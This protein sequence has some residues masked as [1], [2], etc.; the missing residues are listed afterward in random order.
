M[1]ELFGSVSSLASNADVGTRILSGVLSQ[2]GEDL[3]RGV[4]RR[5]MKS[6]CDWAPEA[7]TQMRTAKIEE[8]SASAPSGVPR[9]MQLLAS[10]RSSSFR[11]QN[12]TPKQTRKRSVSD[13]GTPTLPTTEIGPNSSKDS[14]PAVSEGDDDDDNASED[15]NMASRLLNVDSDSLSLRPTAPDVIVTDRDVL[16]ESATWHSKRSGSHVLPLQELVEDTNM[17]SFVRRH[18]FLSTEETVKSLSG[19]TQVA[20]GSKLGSDTRKNN[21]PSPSDG[22]SASLPP[23]APRFVLLNSSVNPL[24]A[25]TA[26]AESTPTVRNLRTRPRSASTVLRE[27]SSS[28]LSISAE[29]LRSYPQSIFSPRDPSAR[30]QLPRPQ[31]ALGLIGL[32]EAGAGM[33]AENEESDTPRRRRRTSRLSELSTAGRRTPRQS[34]I[35]EPLPSL[36][37]SLPTKLHGVRGRSLSSVQTTPQ[38]AAPAARTRSMSP[39]GGVDDFGLISPP[40]PSLSVSAVPSSPHG[41]QHM[42]LLGVVQ[43]ASPER[44]GSARGLGAARPFDAVPE[45]TSMRGDESERPS[46]DNSTLI[47]PAMRMRKRSPRMS[48]RA[49]PSM[50]HR[51]PNPFISK[52]QCDLPASA[53]KA[54]AE[55]YST[56]EGFEER[57]GGVR[58]PAHRR[59]RSPAGLV[60]GFE[61]VRNL[62]TAGMTQSLGLE[63][64]KMES[65]V[66]PSEPSIAAFEDEVDNVSTTDLVIRRYFV[67]D[68]EVDKD[69]AKKSRNQDRP[70]I[71]HVDVL[72]EKWDA[73]SITYVDP[74][75]D[76][77]RKA[78]IERRRFKRIT[79]RPPTRKFGRGASES[80]QQRAQLN[81]TKAVI[82]DVQWM[83]RHPE[84]P[85]H[86]KI[87]YM[88]FPSGSGTR[89]RDFDD[90]GDGTGVQMGGEAENMNLQS[91]VN[92]LAPAANVDKQ[93]NDWYDQ[94]RNL[95]RYYD[96]LVKQLATDGETVVYQAPH[97]CSCG[98]ACC[99]GPS[100]V[101]ANHG[102]QCNKTTKLP[103]DVKSLQDWIVNLD[104]RTDADCKL[105][106]PLCQALLAA[107]VNGKLDFF[108]QENEDLKKELR[109]AQLHF[110]VT[111]RK[112]YIEWGSR[113]PSC[114]AWKSRE[115]HW[116][117][118]AAKAVGQ[119]VLDHTRSKAM[120]RRIRDELHEAKGEIQRLEEQLAAAH[121]REESLKNRVSEL[122]QGL[123]EAK[124]TI[125][126]QRSEMKNVENN[127]KEVH[128]KEL[129]QTYAFLTLRASVI[130]VRERT[131]ARKMAAMAES[132][133]QERDNL[134]SQI[135]HWRSK[136][137]KTETE[138]Q[139]VKE[140]GIIRDYEIL[141]SRNKLTL[142]QKCWEEL[143]EVLEP[144]LNNCP[145]CYGNLL[146]QQMKERV[147]AAAKALGEELHLESMHHM[148]MSGILRCSFLENYLG[149]KAFKNCFIKLEN[150]SAVMKKVNL[151]TR[152]RRGLLAKR[153]SR[154]RASASAGNG[155]NT[156]RRVGANVGLRARKLPGVNV[157]EEIPE[158][159]EEQEVQIKKDIERYD[160][161]VKE[162]VN[163]GMDKDVLLMKAAPNLGSEEDANNV[164][165]GLRSALPSQEAI[166][167]YGENVIQGR[168]G[169]FT[170]TERFK[171]QRIRSLLVD[172]FRG[173]FK[174]DELCVATG[175][176]P[177][178]FSEYFTETIVCET[179]DK[180]K[181]QVKIREVLS[182]L[183]EFGR[184]DR[185][186]YMACRFLGIYEALPTA[187]LSAY[188][189]VIHYVAS[190]FA[191]SHGV[192]NVAVAALAKFWKMISDTEELFWLSRDDVEAI[193]S[194][195]IVKYHV[196]EHLVHHPLTMLLQHEGDRSQ[197]SLYIPDYQHPQQYRIDLHEL[198]FLMTQALEQYESQHYLQAFNTHSQALLHPGKFSY[199]EFCS[200]TAEFNEDLAEQDSR[201]LYV[202]MLRDFADEEGIVRPTHFMLVARSHRALSLHREDEEKAQDKGE[203]SK[204]TSAQQARNRNE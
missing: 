29:E 26:A 59:P 89:S 135:D 181:S 14:L 147:D 112:S 50:A 173:K 111:L 35:L 179:G 104:P 97:L 128:E 38:G 204:Q 44:R 125:F 156:R 48:A 103:I 115:Q 85:K 109:E 77:Q 122:E 157:P 63:V 124:R 27:R 148:A 81:I 30:G 139:A 117:K 83:G 31:T 68:L 24:R 202:R 43:D 116:H 94:H 95:T 153:S 150:D 98:C 57:K 78:A 134:K 178:Q 120:G 159:T 131:R 66:P 87:H 126:E 67:P 91:E 107:V 185:I 40:S 167:E 96:E 203:T 13:I 123:A 160:E 52:T 132:A 106:F 172:M 113:C 3:E 143:Y 182:I 161:E 80:P 7:I 88:E 22:L 121:E 155:P 36:S 90:G 75:R 56:G 177:M 190:R 45:E 142:I 152:A 130:Y 20:P 53:V 82:G 144:T 168:W 86:R 69:P 19:G 137:V 149:E 146:D 15:S 5:L 73:G 8:L 49:S 39:G 162:A 23:S 46:A 197:T 129:C 175:S 188:L 127:I 176:N 92:V 195:F 12:S 171:V 180:M 79:G 99:S 47:S 165:K 2:F 58:S 169:R 151:L 10:K 154:L 16:V 76:A 65:L 164:P 110:L 138:L 105:L 62:P 199:S 11:D 32:Y 140:N 194:R 72:L 37:Q 60:S 141:A 25:A 34:L 158:L 191:A 42:P 21:R 74:E 201:H 193:V 198:L 192:G 33:G 51:D 184:R 54:G 17:T 71:G 100:T 166:Q 119:A 84:A 6:K 4:E 70:Y 9:Q 101:A 93:D 145:R 114:F 186:L 170:S 189:D 41:R 55:G 61:D 200:L 183:A 136:A 118:I 133:T 102:W 64:R 163:L 108:V 18:P 174:A 1:S 187:A 196:S 28:S